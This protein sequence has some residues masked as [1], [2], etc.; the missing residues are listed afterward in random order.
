MGVVGHFNLR[1]CNL[2]VTS[3]LC[4]WFGGNATESKAVA[5]GVKTLGKEGVC[6]LKHSTL[7]FPKSLDNVGLT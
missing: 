3:N 4:T 1:L 7:P 2:L 6:L 5:G